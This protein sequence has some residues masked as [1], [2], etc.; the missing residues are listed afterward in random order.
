MELDEARF[1][2]TAFIGLRV[3]DILDDLD[4]GAAGEFFAG[5]GEG[6]VFVL[7]DETNSGAAF[8]AAEAME[9]LAARSDVKRGGVFVMKWAICLK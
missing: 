3:I 1:R 6:E 2:P 5:I 8:P 7:H 4:A 9:G